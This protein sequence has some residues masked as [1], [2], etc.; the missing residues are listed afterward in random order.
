MSPRFENA[1]IYK[2]EN[3]RSPKIGEDCKRTKSLDRVAK[4]EQ[5]IEKEYQTL[6]DQIV[7]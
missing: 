3:K 5:M 7:L 2:I 6:N 4:L 1:Q